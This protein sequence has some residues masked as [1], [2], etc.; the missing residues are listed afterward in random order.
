MP[1]AAMAL[2]LGSTPLV[3]PGD[4]EAASATFEI[5][6]QPDPVRDLGSILGVYSAENP[7]QFGI[8]QWHTGLAIR[9]AAAGDPDPD[10][11]RSLLYA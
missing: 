2:I 11:W 6:L 9:S 8:D 3:V 7:R 4:R 5:W 1:L 10:G